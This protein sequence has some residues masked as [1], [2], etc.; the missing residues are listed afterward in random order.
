MIET[1]KMYALAIGAS[2]EVI[3]WINIS[4]RKVVEKSTAPVSD[5]EHIIDFLSSDAAP[6]RLQKMSFVDAKRKAKEWS[7]KNQKKGKNLIDSDDDIETIHDFLNGTKIVK[8]KTKKACQ[9]EGFLMSHCVGGYTPS[10]NVHIYSYRDKKNMPHATFEVQKNNNEVVQI[11]GKGNG[12]IHPKYIHPIL[13]FLKSIGMEIRPNDMQNLGYHHIDK[14]HLEFLQKHKDAWAQVT[15]ING[16][17]Y[18][19]DI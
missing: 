14:T 18:A 8:L 2:Q 16:E 5:Y 17:A 3:G 6:K 11:K 19:S 9:R 12:P 13:A 10:E 7:E 4:L 1:L 15:M